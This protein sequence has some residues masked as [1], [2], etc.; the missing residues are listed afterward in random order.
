MRAIACDSA[1][2]LVYVAAESGPVT[3][4]GT[5]PAQVSKV[6]QVHVGPNAHVVE[7]DPATAN[8]YFPLKDLS[9]R[10]ALRIM[11]PG[12]TTGS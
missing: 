2:H 5:Q 8:S 6:G 9:G 1:L 11:N 10:T 12:A 3:V 7:V 4:L